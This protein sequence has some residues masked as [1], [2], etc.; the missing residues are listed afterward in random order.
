MA[1]SPLDAFG[2]T[3]WAFPSL[4]FAVAVNFLNDAAAHNFT[5]HLRDKF[6]LKEGLTHCFGR[7]SLPACKCELNC[8]SSVV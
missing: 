5:S 8:R 1:V 7:C 2:C 6:L 4:F 3:D